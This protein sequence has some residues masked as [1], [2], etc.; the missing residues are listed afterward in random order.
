MASLCS[1]RQS[2][3][4]HLACRKE[5]TKLRY[6]FSL[7]VWCSHMPYDRKERTW[8]WSLFVIYHP[9]ISQRCQRGDLM[10][11][12]NCVRDLPHTLPSASSVSSPNLCCLSPD[13]RYPPQIRIQCPCRAHPKGKGSRVRPL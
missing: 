11:V 3:W 9:S 6:F 5:M 10:L 8:L 2:R 12:C 1:F 13:K 4:R 7:W